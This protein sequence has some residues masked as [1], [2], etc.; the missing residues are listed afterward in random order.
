[1][2]N[3]DAQARYTLQEVLAHPWMAEPKASPT[4]PMRRR[5]GVSY[6][7]SDAVRNTL[8]TLNE[9]DCSCHTKDVAKHGRDSVITQHCDDCSEVQAN[10]P[11]V[12]MRRQILL[13]RN[14]SVS[15]GY[16]SEMG[17]Q[18]LPTPSL[19]EQNMLGFDLFQSST[20]RC[21]VPRKSSAT[22]TCTIIQ[23][24]RCSMP[25][26][27]ILRNE[28]RYADEEDDIVFVW[29]THTR[30][31]VCSLFF[32]RLNS[33]SLYLHI[34][35]SQTQIHTKIVPPKLSAF[36]TI[37]IRQSISRLMSTPMSLVWSILCHK[38]SCFLFCFRFSTISLVC[39]YVLCVLNRYNITIST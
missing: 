12:M 4:K 24:K 32:S 10:D 19:N 25:A 37:T 3:P 34:H 28:E 18:Y 1:M 14:S 11:E 26:P 5:L 8:L 9:C 2:L 29:N 33:D 20:R 7:T 22:S 6:K 39:I 38:T 21:S 30:T 31:H 17:S 23:G 16:G 35:S 36:I 27:N 15:S 13:S